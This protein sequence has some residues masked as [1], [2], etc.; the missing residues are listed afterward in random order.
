MKKH[1]L[2]LSFALL[3]S[4]ASSFAAGRISASLRFL[5]PYTN[6]EIRA[7]RIGSEVRVLASMKN[8]DSLANRNV[9]VTYA[10]SVTPRGSNTPVTISG[11]LGGK[12]TLPP[13]LGGARQTR[14]EFADLAGSQYG[15]DVI[16][17]P[18]FMPA[19]VATMTIT[20][21]TP[22]VGSVSVSRQLTLVL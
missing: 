12:F 21:R 10:L 20:I 22:D 7:A 19:G 18:D 1:A 6:K 14:I 17:I 3:A 16:T 8:F 2:L 15:T 4:S 5:S 13:N 9:T 11:K